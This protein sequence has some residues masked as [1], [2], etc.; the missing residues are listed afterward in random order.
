MINRE[1]LP[2]VMDYSSEI[3]TGICRKKGALPEMRIDAEEARLA[4]IEVLISSLY[5]SVNELERIVSLSS[6]EH[7][8]ALAHYSSDKILPQMLEVRKYSDSL[9]LI[10]S[11]K[12]WPIPTY[13]EML[14]YV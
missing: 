7:G 3:A 9:E 12:H 10:C 11:K 13:G 5:N 4:E 14:F 8:S 2:A 1:I 6:S